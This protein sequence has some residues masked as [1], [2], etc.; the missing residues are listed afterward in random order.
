MGFPAGLWRPFEYLVCLLAVD[1]NEGESAGER[2][3]GDI[4]AGVSEFGCE[5]GDYV[6]GGDGGEG[7]GRLV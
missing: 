1:H 5:E 2:E 3:P 4:V 6:D 7:A